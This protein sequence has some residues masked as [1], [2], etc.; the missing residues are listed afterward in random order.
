MERDSSP[1]DSIE[2]SEIE[3]EVD[4]SYHTFHED[5]SPP[6]SY[7]SF[8][9]F[10]DYEI[11]PI[12]NLVQYQGYYLN[13]TAT[14]PSSSPVPRYSS[15]SSASSTNSLISELVFPLEESNSSLPTSVREPCVPQNEYPLPNLFPLLTT[16]LRETNQT[17]P[18]QNPPLRSIPLPVPPE[19]AGALALST[20]TSSTQTHHCTAPPAYPASTHCTVHESTPPVENVTLYPLG[21]SLPRSSLENNLPNVLPQPF[22]SPIGYTLPGVPPFPMFHYTPAHPTLPYFSLVYVP[23]LMPTIALFQPR[24]P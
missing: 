1:S 15:S 20:S 14:P 13:P 17:Y 2:F 11:D 22:A 4:T 10:V 21:S 23:V 12:S 5:I 16:A 6:S 18:P 19:A 24:L 8:G 3:E 9:S 7:E